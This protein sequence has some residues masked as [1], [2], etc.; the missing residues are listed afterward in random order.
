MKWWKHHRMLIWTYVFSLRSSFLPQSAE[1]S[2]PNSSVSSLSRNSLA[3][4]L[5]QLNWML[6][7]ATRARQIASER[8]HVCNRFSYRLFV[9][10]PE[11]CKQKTL[12]KKR[13]FRFQG[14]ANILFQS[15]GCFFVVFPSIYVF[16]NVLPP[17]LPEILS[18]QVNF[19]K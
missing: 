4:N 9:G 5:A 1:T 7:L 8:F 3:Q 17:K 12:G 13:D 10:C 2:Q 18:V 19:N 16:E 11:R 15:T 14:S 6:P